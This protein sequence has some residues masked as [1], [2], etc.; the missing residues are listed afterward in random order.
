MSNDARYA[1]WPAAVVRGVAGVVGHTSHGLTGS[2]IAKLLAELKLPDPGPVTKADRLE[3]AMV[4]RQS[5]D[6]SSKRLVTLLVHVMAPVLYREDP[7]LFTR[8]QDDL[9]EVLVHVGLKITDEGQV[10]TGATA[11]TL[12]EAARH[13][14]NLRAELLRRGTHPDVL[15]YCTAE[16]LAKDAF[17][18]TLE[19]AKS[20]FDKIRALTQLRGDGAPL[21]DGALGPGKSGQPVLAINSL[22]TQTEQ[23]EQKGLANLIKGVNSMFRNPVAHDPR[24]RRTVTDQELLECLTTLSMIHRR[25]DGATGS[26]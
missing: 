7:G 25:L 1:P 2:K 21:V 23:D 19:A 16:L 24:I 10:A 11:S 9:N 26:S 13:A 4:N 14:N 18:A 12:D 20:V 8:R 6:K 22:D 5:G 3:Y 15:R 17:H